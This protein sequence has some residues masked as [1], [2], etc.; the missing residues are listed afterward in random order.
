[1]LGQIIACRHTLA[2]IIHLSNTSYATM[3]V[4]RVDDIGIYLRFKYFS[5]GVDGMTFILLVI[6]KVES[7]T[8]MLTLKIIFTFESSGK[9]IIFP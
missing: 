2:S 8:R 1:M 3:S 7:S 9:P 4:P 5:S 6:F